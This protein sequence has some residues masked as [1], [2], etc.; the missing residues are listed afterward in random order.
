[1]TLLSFTNIVIIAESEKEAEKFGLVLPEFIIRL[2]QIPGARCEID[3]FPIKSLL[4]NRRHWKT[5]IFT[6]EKIFGHYLEVNLFL[7]KEF[8]IEWKVIQGYERR[9]DGTYNTS[10]QSTTA[11]AMDQIFE[12]SSDAGKEIL[13]FNMDILSNQIGTF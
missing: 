2:S 12:M 11:V 1:M 10:F 5:Y 8:E 9:N 7:S 13:L 3:Q 4:S 6:F